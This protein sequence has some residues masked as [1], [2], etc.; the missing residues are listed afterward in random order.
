M[1]NTD[2][3]R[4]S[5][6]AIT[7]N[8]KTT[9]LTERRRTLFSP[10]RMYFTYHGMPK[11]TFQAETKSNS[12]SRYRATLVWRHQAVSQSAENSILNSITT[13]D[14]ISSQSESFFG[15]SLPNQYWT[16]HH[17]GKLRL[18]V[19]VFCGPSLLLHGPCYEPLLWFVI[20]PMKGSTL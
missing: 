7:C 1:K 8:H 2:D 14:S 20:F 5:K 12:K 3:F 16:H 15:L 9:L 13:F 19:I 18:V 10:W 17:L 11:G 4:Y 6:V